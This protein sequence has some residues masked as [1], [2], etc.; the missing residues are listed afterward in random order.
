MRQWAEQQRDELRRLKR[1][2][3]G[4]RRG[5]IERDV[6]D[7]LQRWT[8][9]HPSTLAHRKRH[10][11]AWA[12]AFRGRHRVTLT[13]GEIEQQLAHWREHG[14]DPKKSKR[15]APATITK[16]RQALYQLYAVLD[17]GKLLPNPVAQV[18]PPPAPEVEPRGVPLELLDLVFGEMQPSLTRSRLRL[19]AYAGL[20]PIEVLR[21]QWGDYDP[22]AQTLLVPQAKTRARTRLP[23]LPEA[24]EALR[25]LHARGALTTD[26]ASVKVSNTAPWNVTLRRA[27]KRVNTAVKLDPPLALRV[28]DLRHSY[29]TAVYLA[30]G[31]QRAAQAALRHAHISTTDRYTLAAVA[32]QMRLALDALAAVQQFPPGTFMLQPCEPGPAAYSATIAPTVSMRRAPVVPARPGP[33]PLPAAARC[34]SR[35]PAPSR[36]PR[37]CARAP[38]SRRQP[39]APRSAPC[40]ARPGTTQRPPW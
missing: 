25:D 19:C 30:A 17:R 34:R 21:I 27:V 3:P 16:I 10:L 37:W 23:L 14:L 26:P 1:L 36:T 4:A 2:S 29:G 20:M 35:T 24:I 38:S 39:R 33:T 40:S 9:R 13:P 7:Y 32:P 6:E 28:Y 8:A 31:D 22:A 15:L 18:P 5:T 12:E 11:K